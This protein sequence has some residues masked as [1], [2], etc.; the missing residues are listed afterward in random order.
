MLKAKDIRDQSVDEIKATY[1]DI[2]KELFLLVNEMKL[3]KKLEKPHLIQEKKRDIARLLTV[4]NEK[5]KNSAG[6]IE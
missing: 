6:G 3:T 1:R 2:T 4:L 5:K